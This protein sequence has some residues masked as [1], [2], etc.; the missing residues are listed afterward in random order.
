MKIGQCEMLYL[1]VVGLVITACIGMAVYYTI[2]NF[3]KKPP[4]K[5]TDPSSNDI[6][7]RSLRFMKNEANR[8]GITVHHVAKA[9]TCVFLFSFV[10]W[11]SVATYN[12]VTIVECGKGNVTV[13]IPDSAKRVIVA[14][15]L[16][17]GCE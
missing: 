7:S 10:T 3:L 13:K 8:L 16:P 2:S 11:G 9:I 4:T 12:N 1:V 15:G 6:V 5:P 17:C 14:T